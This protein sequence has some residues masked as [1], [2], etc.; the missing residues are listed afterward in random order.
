[1]RRV[2]TRSLRWLGVL[3]PLAAWGGW[4]LV[5]ALWWGQPLLAA[6]DW[7]ELLL[8]GGGATWFASWVAA[9]LERHEAEIRRRS[10]HLEA[11]RAAGL[12]LTTELELDK[13]LQQ[14]VDQ[15]RLLVGAQYSALVVLGADGRSIRCTPRAWRRGRTVWGLVGWEGRVLPIP[16]GWKRRLGPRKSAP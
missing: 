15:G 5:R 12:A 2:D 1:M 14:V 6:A 9:H 3:V 7:V 16:S 10:D 11:L 8:I 13:V 4:E